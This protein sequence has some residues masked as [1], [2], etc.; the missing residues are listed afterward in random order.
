METLNV[1]DEVVK[2]I[3]AAIQIDPG[4]VNLEVTFDALGFDSLSNVG[5]VR[6]LEKIFDCA[7]D[8]E[9]L[10]DHPNA[11]MLSEHI[12]RLK[13]LSNTLG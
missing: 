11:R 13:G 1:R 7:L 2:A 12:S 9:V 5:I 8:P 4:D 3:A 10:F 6:A